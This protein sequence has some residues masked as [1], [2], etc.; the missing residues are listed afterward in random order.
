ME[1][2]MCMYMR[3]D[4]EA[5]MLLRRPKLCSSQ[6]IQRILCGGHDHLPRI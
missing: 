5:N 4:Y 3:Q 6:N 1:F 2:Y